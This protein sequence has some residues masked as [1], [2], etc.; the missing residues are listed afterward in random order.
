MAEAADDE[1]REFLVE[2]REERLGANGLPLRLRHDVEEGVGVEV[3][4][5]DLDHLDGELAEESLPGGEFFRAVVVAGEI[6][7]IQRNVDTV[8][9]RI[10][11]RCL[12]VIEVVARAIVGVIALVARADN[13]DAQ[14][15]ETSVDDFPDAFRIARIGIHVDL[16]LFRLRPDE[17]D[18]RMPAAML[19]AARLGSPSQPWPKLTMPSGATE[20]W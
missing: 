10:A 6:Q 8:V 14:A 15:V 13:R 1:L 11:D 18:R 3:E 9:E 12:D 4:V 17:L 5:A 7:E 2:R 19:S 20:R 16:A